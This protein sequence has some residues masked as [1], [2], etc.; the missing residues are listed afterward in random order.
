MYGGTKTE[1]ERLIADANRVKEANG[2]MANLSI[3]S[4]ADV[5]EAIHIVQTEMG[6]TGTTAEEASKTIS[7]SVTSMKAAW[8]N[9][10]TGIGD[11]NANISVLLDEFLVSVETV[12][13]NLLPVIGRIVSGIFQTLESRGPEMIAEGVLLIGK[14]AV[15]F[16]EA[17]PDLVSKI[18]ELIQSVVDAFTERAADFEG[19]GA[20]I[21]EGLWNGI[22]SLTGWLGEKVNGFLDGLFAGAQENEEIH[23]PSRKWARFGANMAAGLAVGW[24]EEFLN[25]SK[26]INGSLDF[27][28]KEI[29]FESSSIGGASAGVVNGIGSS[30]TGRE[31]ER[32]ITVNLMM[33]DGTQFASYILGPLADY[34][35]ANGTPLL[36]PQ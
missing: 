28:T 31:S 21:V 25:V 8:T 35:K 18:P 1:M 24:D 34:A 29:G 17:I 26:S 23:S 16:I 12:G 7:G 5:T 33:P 6:I 32:S 27:G 20:R 4:F 13:V 30:V 11:S 19:I 9:L 14:L 36:S 2:E 15:G 3:D 22:K 10:V